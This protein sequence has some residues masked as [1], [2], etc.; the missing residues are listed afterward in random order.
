MPGLG[1][2]LNGGKK[3]TV[4][5]ELCV[6]GATGLSLVSAMSS[7]ALDL[8]FGERNR[9][10]IVAQYCKQGAYETRTAQV[11]TVRVSFFV[12]TYEPGLPQYGEV[13][14]DVGLPCVQQLLQIRNATGALKQIFQ[15]R[16]P[17]GMPQQAQ[18]FG[19]FAPLFGG[20]G[21]LGHDCGCSLP[22]RVKRLV[23]A[24]PARRRSLFFQRR[25]PPYLI[26]PFEYANIQATAGACFVIA[27]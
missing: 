21:F 4:F 7:P 22:G 19:R 27:R 26:V 11:V 5:A 12:E 15:Q 23:L 14:R 16:E 1:S 3:F 18:E 2:G 13:L 17:E 25:R 24:P 8:L 20:F 6:S 10:I 9:G